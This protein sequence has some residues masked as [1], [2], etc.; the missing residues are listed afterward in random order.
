M[1]DY[2]AQA[3]A[4]APGQR[5]W[6][7]PGRKRRTAVAMSGGWKGT[8]GSVPPRPSP[9]A[10]RPRPNAGLSGLRR[11]RRRTRMR[12]PRARNCGGR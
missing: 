5:R 11:G 4:R 8:G 1:A 6:R 7:S 2:E 10:P 3:D 12:G 9:S